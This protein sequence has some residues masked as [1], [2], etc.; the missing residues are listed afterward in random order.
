MSAARNSGIFQI[1]GA[2]FSARVKVK[3]KYGASKA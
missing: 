2:C 1:K 3:K